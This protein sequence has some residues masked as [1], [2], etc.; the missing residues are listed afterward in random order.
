MLFE[1]TVKSLNKI[2]YPGSGFLEATALVMALNRSGDK[3]VAVRASMKKILELNKESKQVHL[4]ML[5]TLFQ[6]M[7]GE[8]TK[9]VT[10]RDLLE[11]GFEDSK[12]PK[13]SDYWDY[14]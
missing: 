13:I 2:D 3:G 1:S 4:E 6:L 9:V 8:V 11:L 14:Y 5:N 10:S 12:E 7:F